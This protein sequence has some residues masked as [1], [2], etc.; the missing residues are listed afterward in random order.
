MCRQDGVAAAVKRVMQYLADPLAAKPLGYRLWTV[1][2]GRLR[3]SDRKAIARHIERMESHPLISVL[4]TVD[5]ARPHD[6]RRAIESVRK[7][8]YPY[9]EL[10]IAADAAVPPRVAEVLDGY[11]RKDRRIKLVSPPRHPREGGNPAG[12]PWI[13]G[14]SP[15]MTAKQTLPS[16]PDLIRASTPLSGTTSDGVSQEPLISER[17]PRDEGGAN[18][19]ALSLAGGEFVALMGPDDHLPDH[20]LYAVAAEINKHPRA[21]ILYSDE[22]GI[23]DSV[24]SVRPSLKP[25]WSPDLFTGHNYIGRICVLRHS[26]VAAVGGFR[27]QCEGCQDYDLLLRITAAIAPDQIRHIPHVLY[28]R[29]QEATRLSDKAFA[30]A[31]QAV[32]DHLRQSGSPAE[33]VC[34]SGGTGTLR[35]RHSL[36]DPLPR[37]SIIIPTRDRLDLLRQC[38]DGLLFGTDYPDLEIII[39]DNGSEEPETLSYF[40]DLAK[41]G[42]RLLRD[43]GPFNYSALNNKAVAAASGSVIVLLNN[44]TKVIHADWLREMVSQACR[45]DVGAVGAKLY[46][47]DGRLQHAGVVIGLGGVAGHLHI[48]LSRTD[49][50]HDDEVALVRNVSCVTAA[51]MALRKSVF[52]EVG[53]LDAVRLPVAFNDVDLC[54]KIRERGYLIVWTPFAELYH[55]ESASRGSDFSPDKIARFRRDQAVIKALWGA[56]LAEDPYYNPNRTHYGFRGGL[57]FPPRVER[58]WRKRRFQDSLS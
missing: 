44:D 27:P 35:V 50:G 31:R 2:Y 7:Q 39:V 10:C 18:N 53:G 6:L 11:A 36:P 4:M 30:L 22:D 43:D 54:L 32:A 24:G 37:V 47:P 45:P 41:R 51:C 49:A 40:A 1:L 14:S 20:A 29:R 25:D 12:G 52:E 8:L 23:V 58:P 57:A 48:G 46:F 15:A 16:C 34:A 13:A 42:V 26:R 21:D 56:T 19:A 38:V 9:W 28:H 17:F 3:R 33:V 5:H 55:F